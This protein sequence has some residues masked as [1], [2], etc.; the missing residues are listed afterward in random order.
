MA[1]LCMTTDE[2]ITVPLPDTIENPCSARIRGPRFAGALQVDT[3][4][5]DVL[6]AR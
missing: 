5:A 6:G 3:H 1:D 2:L 4:I